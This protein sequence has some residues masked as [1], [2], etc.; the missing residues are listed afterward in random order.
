MAVPISDAAG[1]YL[2]VRTIRDLG[3]QARYAEI[4]EDVQPFYET[5]PV[6]S[7]ALD[8]LS[9]DALAENL[10]N[11]T[12]DADTYFCASS[13]YIPI[14]VVLDDTENP[15][16]V[17]LVRAFETAG[18]K[19]FLG[20]AAWVMLE[21][22]SGPV[23]SLFLTR[24]VRRPLDALLRHAPARLPDLSAAGLRPGCGIAS[25]APPAATAA[26]R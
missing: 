23:M 25:V 20:D 13:N 10:F 4:P 18:G 3:L 24:Y 12:P 7:L 1:V 26:D 22:E 11:S 19:A 21:E 15:K 16:L 8:G 14:L 5:A 17:E 6:S 9:F 2:L